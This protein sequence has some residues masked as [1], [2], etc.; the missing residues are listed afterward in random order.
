[1]PTDDAS[2]VFNNMLSIYERGLMKDFAKATVCAKDV[3]F[4]QLDKLDAIY[5]VEESIYF[6]MINF[7]LHKVTVNSK[8]KQKL[9][10]ATLKNNG[11]QYLGLEL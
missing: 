2:N 6:K 10:L 4:L 3:I 9:I 11:K 5:S 1:M 7:D 8:E